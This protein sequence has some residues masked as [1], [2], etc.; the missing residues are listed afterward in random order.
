M[1]CLCVAAQGKGTYFAVNFSLSASDRFAKPDEQG[2]KRILL[3]RVITGNFAVGNPTM[4]AAPV[5]DADKSIL[6]HS[7]VN[8]LADPTV[9]VTF[10]DWAAYP[11]YMINFKDD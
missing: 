6:C 7:V 3:C 10:N 9:F 2:V 1:C 8:S 5:Y 11:H 4:K